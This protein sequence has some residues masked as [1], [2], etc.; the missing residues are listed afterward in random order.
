MHA[1]A[2]PPAYELYSPTSGSPQLNE[3]TSTRW[4]ET[5]QSTASYSPAPEFG[6][7]VMAM[8]APG[9]DACDH[10]RSRASSRAQPGLV[11]LVFRS[12]GPGTGELYVTVGAASEKAESN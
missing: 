6:E 2:Q 4:F 3:I 12:A 9:A 7:N 8:E 5:S 1:L 11:E 10:S